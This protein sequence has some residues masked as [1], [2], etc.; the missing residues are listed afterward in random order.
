MAVDR[1]RTAH[2]RTVSTKGRPVKVLD[3]DCP[4]CGTPPGRYCFSV[5]LPARGDVRWCCC[6]D[7]SNAAADAELPPSTAR[8]DKPAPELDGQLGL[9]GGEGVA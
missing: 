7:R 5:T 9:F 8:L 2:L 6:I 3:I 4:K 1:P